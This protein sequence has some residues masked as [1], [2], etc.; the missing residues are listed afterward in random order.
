[1]QQ[2]VVLLGS[3]IDPAKNLQAAVER[4]R[5]QTSVDV[6]AESGVYE[7]PTVLAS[8]ELDLHRPLFLNA[9]VRLDTEMSE[10]DLR[11]T[12]R[13]IETRLGRERHDDK[14]AD[15]P[16]DLDIVAVRDADGSITID[17]DVA[18]KAFAALPVADVAGDWY[19]PTENRSL[20]EIARRLKQND[21]RIRRI[22]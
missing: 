19:M 7:S 5:S 11:S 15:R 10:R 3:N 21:E 20:E 6:V 1:M 17:P 2:F 14:F 9:A 16:I 12:L 18:A 13:E 8:G 22:S 4:L